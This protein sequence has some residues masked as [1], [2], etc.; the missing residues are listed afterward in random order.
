MKHI[1]FAVVAAA[2]LAVVGPHLSGPP[3]SAT[4]ASGLAD[5]S[6]RHGLR[7]TGG[8]IH[9]QASTGTGAPVSILRIRA[10]EGSSRR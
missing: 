8:E 4:A 9:G 3:L 7:P 5:I 2:A 1:A 6:P 10:G